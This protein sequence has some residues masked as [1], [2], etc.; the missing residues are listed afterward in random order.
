M[1]DLFRRGAETLVASWEAY[2][3]AAPGAAVHRAPGIAA[4]V[5][6]DAPERDIYNN[7]LVERP[8]ALDEVESIYA[9][10]GVTRFAAWVHDADDA[11]RTAVATRGYGF[12]SSTRAMA[13]PLTDLR[14]AALR[15]DVAPIDWSEHLTMFELSPALLAG[16]MSA[17]HVLGV[18]VD[19]TT[20][21]SAIAFDHDGDCGIYNVGTLEPFRRRGL[22]GA[23]TAVL[24]GDAVARGCTTASVQSTLM[25]EGVYS[26][27]GFR[28]LGR[29]LEYV[30]Q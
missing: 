1:T 15:I 10:A 23:L 24:L 28:D 18:R 4:A 13:M 11:T 30:P 14:P 22:G 21:A 7:A 12:D 8:D 20:V 3:R 9:A 25:A 2:A 5:F 26:S 29:Y 17:F 19:G 27:V 16:D 6:P